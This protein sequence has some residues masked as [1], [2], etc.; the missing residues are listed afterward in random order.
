MLAALHRQANEIL[1]G[2]QQ[3]FAARMR[4]L[5]GHPVVVNQWSS[6]C[7]PCTLEA[8]ILERV[9]ARYGSRVAFLGNDVEDPNLA[10]ARAW[11]RRFPVSYPSYH[12]S[13]MAIASL[14]SS[15]FSSYKPVT[16]FYDRAG[17]QVGVEIGQIVS[18]AELTRDLRRYLGV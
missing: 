5:R 12:D 16:Y 9:A 15:E 18:A 6:S 11:L 13:G 8:S 2:G 3:A 7:G 17:R 1:G 14:L 4:S 10:A